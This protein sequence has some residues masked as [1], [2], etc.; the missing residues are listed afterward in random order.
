[1]D[2]GGL[3]PEERAEVS[4]QPAARGGSA[5][6]LA[7]VGRQVLIGRDELVPPCLGV[8]AVTAGDVGGEI[9]GV[10]LPPGPVEGDLVQVPWTSMTRLVWSPSAVSVAWMVSSNGAAPRPFRQDSS[11]FLVVT[12]SRRGGSRASTRPVTSTRLIDGTTFLDDDARYAVSVTAHVRVTSPSWSP[13]SA[14]P[15]PHPRPPARK[16]S[17]QISDCTR[18]GGRRPPRGERTDRLIA[19]SSD[20]GHSEAAIRISPPTF[21]RP[22]PN[23]ER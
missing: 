2:T 20:C 12:S 22:A 8:S 19:L 13:S 4:R 3:A 1:M 10:D 15:S 5:V 21:T 7:D 6:V 18:R 16:S 11:D 23:A 9:L 14:K 17:Q